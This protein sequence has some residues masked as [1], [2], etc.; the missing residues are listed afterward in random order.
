VIFCDEGVLGPDN[1]VLP[2]VAQITGETGRAATFAD[3]EKAAL[4]NALRNNGGNILKTA[5]ELQLA[6][7]TLYNKMK[8]YNL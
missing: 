3:I 2:P 1:F 8:K 6:R 5:R 4:E 7:Q